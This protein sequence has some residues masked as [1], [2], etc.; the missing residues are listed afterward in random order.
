MYVWSAGATML[1]SL[2]GL[3]RHHQCRRQIPPTS[4][5]CTLRGPVR[6]WWT[7]VGRGRWGVALSRVLWQVSTL[8]H[9]PRR[10]PGPLAVPGEVAE[11]VT[12]QTTSWQPAS[13]YPVRVGKAIKASA[14]KLRGYPLGLQRLLCVTAGLSRGGRR[15]RLLP[16]EDLLPPIDAVG[17]D[18]SATAEMLADRYAAFH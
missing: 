16:G 1:V 15:S 2:A 13:R 10:T 9:R 6:P 7:V 8:H 17:R 18:P 12:A 14:V 3:L 4:P 11:A 5:A